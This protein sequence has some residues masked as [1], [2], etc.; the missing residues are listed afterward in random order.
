MRCLRA[1]GAHERTRVYACSGIVL[2]VVWGVLVAAMLCNRPCGFGIYA[3]RAQARASFSCLLSLQ[4]SAI[5]PRHFCYSSTSTQLFPADTTRRR[6]RRRCCKTN[7]PHPPPTCCWCYC[8]WRCSHL[9]L[10][11]ARVVVCCLVALRVA[12]QRQKRES[13]ACAL[14]CVALQQ[15]A[16]INIIPAVVVDVERLVGLV[17]VGWLR[18]VSICLSACLRA[19]RARTRNLVGPR[20]RRQRRRRS[21]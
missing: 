3:R 8:C 16:N 21:H 13:F 17:E 11:C 15:P 12:A 9:Y 10:F 1:C 14:R 6:R 7:S 2:R 18:K 19:R 4:Q 20:W 5:A